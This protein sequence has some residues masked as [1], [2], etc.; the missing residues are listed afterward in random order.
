MMARSSQNPAPVAKELFYIRP[1]RLDD[2]ATDLGDDT[3]KSVERKRIER[4]ADRLSAGLGLGD[5]LLHQ[6]PVAKAVPRAQQA[7]EDQVV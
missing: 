4:R 6:K 5:Q 2:L 1:R 7:P 3:N